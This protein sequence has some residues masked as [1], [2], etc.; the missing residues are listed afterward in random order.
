MCHRTEMSCVKNVVKTFV[1]RFVWSV[2]ATKDSGVTHSDTSE[3][4]TF[5]TPLRKFFTFSP[6]RRV[7][8]SNFSITA[9]YFWQ[10]IEAEAHI[11]PIFSMIVH[12]RALSNQFSATLR[13]LN[14]KIP[15]SWNLQRPHCLLISKPK[16][17]QRGSKNFLLPKFFYICKEKKKI[18]WRKIYFSGYK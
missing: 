3:S 6:R 9:D 15:T 4:Q 12:D 10:T 18:C 7:K 11:S 2:E 17:V 8:F 5:P 13:S 16:A 1:G 14:I